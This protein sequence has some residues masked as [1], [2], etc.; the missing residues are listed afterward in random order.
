[1]ITVLDA[2]AAIEIVLQREKAVKLSE[3]IIASDWVTAPTLFI[4]EVVNTVWKY[5][6]F[7]DLPFNVCEK[8]LEQ[9]LALPD[10]FTNEQ[11]LFREVFKLSCTLDHPSYD[12]FYLV[13]ARR[14]NATLLTLNRKLVQLAVKCS[15]DVGIL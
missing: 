11:D 2:S 14:N 3:Y 9:A 7:A 8:A 5:Q 13:T 15:V 1:M 12:I 4:S 10:D 6:K